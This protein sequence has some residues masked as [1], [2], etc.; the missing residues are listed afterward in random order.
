MD[1]LGLTV[2]MVQDLL[3]KIDLDLSIIKQLCEMVVRL[4]SPNCP[5]S[6]YVLLGWVQVP[7]PHDQGGTTTLGYPARSLG[8]G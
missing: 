4:F 7:W 3:S 6:P 5:I 2:Q 1:T 8:I